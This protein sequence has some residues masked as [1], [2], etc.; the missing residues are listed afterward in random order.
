MPL[1][2]RMPAEIEFRV[3][4]QR[5]QQAIDD[6]AAPATCCT[7]SAMLCSAAPQQRYSSRCCCCV[8]AAFIY[9]ATLQKR[10]RTCVP[11]AALDPGL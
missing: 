10:L 3:P 6:T 7:S 2:S 5:T 4:W 9:V 11:R 1:Y 8:A